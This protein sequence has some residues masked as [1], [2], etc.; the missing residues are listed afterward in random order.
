MMSLTVS[1]GKDEIVFTLTLNPRSKWH[2]WQ[3]ILGA[4]W[5]CIVW[6]VSP[7]M[8]ENESN[9]QTTFRIVLFAVINLTLAGFGFAFFLFVSLCLAKLTFGG[10]DAS[11]I[12][13]SVLLFCVVVSVWVLTLKSLRKKSEGVKDMKETFTNTHT[14]LGIIVGVNIALCCFGLA[15]S[16]FWFSSVCL[17]AG[18][19]CIIAV[20]YPSSGLLIVAVILNIV[21]AAL[22]ITTVVQHLMDLAMRESSESCY[23]YFRYSMRSQEDN[24][25]YYNNLNKV[26]LEGVHIMMTV[27]SGLQ[28]CVTFS[29]IFLT[30][31]VMCKKDG[32]TKS[33][34][35][36]QAV[37][38][39]EEMG[40]VV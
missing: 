8:K 29:F 10:L 37:M 35:K 31:K 22:A 11:T 32:G 21:N 28:F 4:L 9:I 3:Q 16:Y 12:F 6:S 1:Q 24:C 33:E 15:G 26:F 27:L 19:V 7:D 40:I 18:I 2:I 17:L 25:K 34:E 20:K 23:S 30:L 5:D 13:M 36:P 14:A 38:Q 39:A